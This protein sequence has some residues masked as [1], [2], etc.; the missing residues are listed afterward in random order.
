MTASPITWAV[1]ADFDMGGSYE[2][3]LGGYVNR[4]SKVVI[5]CGMN[6]QGVYQVSKVNIGL[7]NQTGDFTP[8]NSAGA[9]YGLLRPDV[10]VRITG[11]HLGIAYT[12]WTGYAMRWKAERFSIGEGRAGVECQDLAAYLKNITGID[13]LLSTSRDT[14]GAITAIATAAGLVGGDLSL[15]DGAQDLPYHWVRNQD[16]LTAMI[17]AAQSEMGGYLWVN[18]AGQVRFENRTSRL[19]TT[20]DDTWGDGTNIQPEEIQYELVDQDTITSSSVQATIYATGQADQELLRFD[21]NMFHRP[22]AN[23]I[24]IPAGGRYGPVDLDYVG[25]AAAAALT[26]PVEYTDYTGNLAI[27]GSSTDKTTSLSPV[28]VDLGAA[29]RLYIDNTDLSNGVYVTAFRLRGQVAD[30]ARETPSYVFTKS[31]PLVKAL[32]GFQTKVPFATDTSKVRDFAYGILRT[33][34]LPYPRLTLDFPWDNDDTIAAMLA[35]ELGQLIAFDDTDANPYG[36]CVNDWWYVEKRRHTIRPDGAG[37]VNRS[38]ITLLP[39][40]LYR[41][42][43]AIAYDLFTRD[44][45]VGDLGTSTSEDTWASDSGFDIS[46]NKARPNAAALQ[47]PYVS[48]A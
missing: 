28:V 9:F 16:A 1:E 46:A 6:D 20:P 40:Y 43:E 19:G 5:D 45:V 21:R 31:V 15:D 22:D 7:N 26:T 38:Q 18:A 4:A 33:Y 2:T 41:N 24:L 17:E 29:A 36:S 14:A 12:L 3:A 39:S 23:S 34:R 37:G 32:R 10:P 42:L 47:T 48:I 35:V 11:T 8:E 44:D 30:F 13:V 25:F 27:D